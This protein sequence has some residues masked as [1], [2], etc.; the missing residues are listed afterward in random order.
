[1]QMRITG[2]YDETYKFQLRTT[3]QE[4]AT[5]LDFINNTQHAGF[6]DLLTNTL[7]SDLRLRVTIVACTGNC[8][9]RKGHNLG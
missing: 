3:R 2:E 5:F 7:N 4:P 8:F 6:C 1:M 9:L